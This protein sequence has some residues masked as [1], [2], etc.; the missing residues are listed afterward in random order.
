VDWQLMVAASEML[1]SQATIRT[2]RCL[3]KF[4]LLLFIIDIVLESG[5]HPYS[6]IISKIINA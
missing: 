4:L 2:G 3:V 1:A 5:T 6:V